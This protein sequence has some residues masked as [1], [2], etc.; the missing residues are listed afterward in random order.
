MNAQI[1]IIASLSQSP[2]PHVCA[3]ANQLPYRMPILRTLLPQTYT[4]R[5]TAE[6][7]D[8]S[9]GGLTHGQHGFLNI[10]ITPL[11]CSIVCHH[12]W[13]RNVFMPVIS[14]LPEGRTGQVTISKDTYMVLSVI[15]AG[16]DAASRVMELTSPLALA[17]IPI[18]FITTYYSDFICVPT[19]ER[20]NVNSTLLAHGFQLS[21]ENGSSYVP[22]G[23]LGYPS[24]TNS[25]EAPSPT[26]DSS[27]GTPLPSNVDELMSRT[28]DL[29]RKRA[30][31]PYAEVDLELVQCSGRDHEMQN[32]E[33]RAPAHAIHGRR[34]SAP[35]GW[36]DTAD[37]SLYTGIISALVSHPRFC[38]VTLAQED[39]PSLLLDRKLLPFFGNSLVGDFES[40]MTPIFLDLTNLPTEVT[41][42]VCG[43]AGRLLHEMKMESS[44]E[45]SYLSTAK[46]G[47]VILSEIQAKRALE[48]LKPIV[49]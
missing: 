47:S 13:A 11:E 26:S 44:S 18:F 27:P 5:V 48:I 32:S 45:L 41:G 43:V 12:E 4:V 15:S 37:T 35:R 19:K 3:C 36:I 25:A 31:V 20:H 2:T 17:G 10:T 8:F 40:T 9:P 33:L 29:L 21:S 7:P 24:S 1:S 38:S 14:T 16:M 39:P 46:A 6:G 23:F 34:G 30:V 22:P 28:F 49:E 42:I